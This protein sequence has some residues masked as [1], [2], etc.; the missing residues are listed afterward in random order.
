MMQ[1]QL[2]KDLICKT[3]RVNQN[4]VYFSLFFP[5]ENDISLYYIRFIKVVIIIDLGA[6][7][8]ICI[9]C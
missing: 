8:K 9:K 4:V 5:Y 6:K 2:T 7:T 1:V 3:N